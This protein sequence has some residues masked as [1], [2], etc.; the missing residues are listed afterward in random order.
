MCMYLNQLNLV[1]QGSRRWP[2]WLWGQWGP[3]GFIRKVQHSVLPS[4]QLDWCTNQDP[5]KKQMAHSN[6]VLWRDIVGGLF[7]N[8]KVSWRSYKYSEATD[9]WIGR[10]DCWYPRSEGER[11]GSSYQNL[12]TDNKH[13]K[14]YVVTAVGKSL[15]SNRDIGGLKKLDTAS[16]KWTC[17]WAPQLESQNKGGCWYRSDFCRNSRVNSGSERENRRH[18]KP[19]RLI[20]ELQDYGCC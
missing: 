8:V 17:P 13:R 10:K 2:S 3:C 5:D 12:E 14:R 11:V 16:P 7:I 4:M 20:S 1:F 6:W 15:A 19:K 9:S 18:K